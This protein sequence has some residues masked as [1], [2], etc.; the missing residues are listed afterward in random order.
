MNA[1]AIERSVRSV[2]TV[3]NGR[4]STSVGQARDDGW[5]ISVRWAPLVT[6]GWLGASL[7]VVGGIL[8]LAG[9][10]GI[11]PALA[12]LALALALVGVTLRGLPHR[13]GPPSD[14]A[15][16]PPASLV[17]ERGAFLGQFHK[18]SHWLIISDSYAS[19][20]QTRDAAG[21]LQS[22]IR[23]HPR[24]YALWLGLGNALTDHA[25]RLTPAASFAFAR[26]ADLAPA[27]PA[28]GYFL[29]VA[30]MRSGD[31]R[32]AVAEWRKILADAPADASW[33]PLVE[34][35]LA[36]VVAVDQPS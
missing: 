21:I 23:A 13:S 31:T 29:G 24:D 20:G 26:S 11:W 32:G 18:T 36:K 15:R 16:D 3:W 8:A 4:L 17:G 27:S 6:L 14:V 12:T 33:R 34:D 19:R 1:P 30:K 5:S 25:G 2:T 28:P 7:M 10:R 22:A 35:R 9:L